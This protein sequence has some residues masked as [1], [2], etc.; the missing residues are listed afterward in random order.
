MQ[1]ILLNTKKF[2]YTYWALENIQESTDLIELFYN[3]VLSPVGI[4]IS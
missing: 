3:W 1:N 4:L 2:K